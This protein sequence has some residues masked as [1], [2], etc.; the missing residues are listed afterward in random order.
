M[1]INC[2]TCANEKDCLRLA[3]SR[4]IGNNNDDTYYRNLVSMY[5]CHAYKEKGE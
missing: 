4:S 1:V 3:T 2:D 5:G